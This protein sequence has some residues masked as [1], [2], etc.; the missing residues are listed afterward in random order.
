MMRWYRFCLAAL[1]IVAGSA[2]RAAVR[3][4][5]APPLKLVQKIELSDIRTGEPEVSADQLAKN[6]TTTRMPGVQNHFDH[7]TA[8]LKGS[9]IFV[10]PEDN[11]SVEVYDI[12]SGKFVH[13]IKGIGV[14]HS[15]VYRADI[16]RIF[17]TD[18]SEGVLHIY[19]ATYAHLKTVKLLTDAD[20]T[21]YDRVTHYLYIANGGLDANLNYGLLSVVDTN[22]G[23][24]VGD[25]KIDSNRLEAM[26]IEKSG[27]RL[28]LNA[29]EKNAIAVID[30][31]KQTVVATWPATGCH[32]NAG[33]A[34]DESHHR[35]FVACRDG[36][37]VVMDSDNG[38]VLQTLPI[39][40]GVDDLVYDPPSQRIYVA[41]GEGFVNVYKQIDADHYQS[42]GKIPTGPLGKTGLLVPELK[43]YFVAV[44]PHGA[45]AAE[46]LVF[47]VQ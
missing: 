47:A 17:I 16:D 6:L 15:V 12:R 4:E 14:G 37:L 23:E 45:A 24:R 3:A 26:V 33:V 8:D 25:I 2:P 31:K 21:G 29:T 22:T 13:S 32:V 35:L 10:V 5:D 7:L 11:K 42:I 43:K 1:I 44:P 38:K 20:A 39:S 46:V 30:R 19:G 9:R 18:G 41:C 34:I 40:T 36:N 28:F 27:P